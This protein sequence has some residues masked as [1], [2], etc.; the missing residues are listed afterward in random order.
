MYIK[1]ES[2]VD[3]INTCRYKIS[4]TKNKNK[5]TQSQATLFWCCTQ[6]KLSLVKQNKHEN[7][8]KAQLKAVSVSIHFLL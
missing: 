4:K 8:E 6:P 7:E 2:E 5:T 1:T 3:Q